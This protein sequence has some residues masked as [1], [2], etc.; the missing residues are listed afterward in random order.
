M[1]HI[2]LQEG[3]PGIIG[4]LAYRPETAQRPLQL[5]EV[6]LRGPNNLTSAEREMIAAYV[7]YRNDCRFCQLSHDAAAMAHL[8]GHGELLDRVK[9]NPETAEISEKLKALLNIAGLVQKGGK[10]VMPADIDR[11]RQH[12]AS[13]K[14][15]HDTVLIAA[16]FSMYNRYVD[17]LGTWQPEEPDAYREMGERMAHEGYGRASKSASREV[18]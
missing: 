6:L 17:G 9:G 11:A 12:A 13:D 3:L 18:A 16:A 5:A 15:I 14:E 2:E 8:G 10:N 7:S 1:A 4:L